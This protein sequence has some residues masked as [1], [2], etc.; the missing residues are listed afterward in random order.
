MNLYEKQKFHAASVIG[1]FLL[2]LSLKVVIL[3]HLDSDMF[4]IVLSHGFLIMVCLL[5]HK[6]WVHTVCQGIYYVLQNIV[7]CL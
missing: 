3:I 1:F 2:L 7:F 4:H 6:G 5:S